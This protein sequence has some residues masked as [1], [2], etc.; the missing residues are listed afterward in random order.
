MNFDLYLHMKLALARIMLFSVLSVFTLY[1]VPHEAVHI[2]YS[3]VDTEH[4]H[5]SGADWEFSEKHIHC[6][7][8]SWYL[9]EFLPGELTR[10]ICAS[11]FQFSKYNIEQISIAQVSQPAE[12]NR[13]PPVL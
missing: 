8:L 12:S 3:H 13:G 10:Q 6:D 7:F 2:F 1:L 4:A 9:S 11:E 5:S